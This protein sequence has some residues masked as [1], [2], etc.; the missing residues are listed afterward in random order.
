MV[1]LRSLQPMSKDEVHECL[2]ALG[3]TDHLYGLVAPARELKK[4]MNQRPEKPT[5]WKLLLTVPPE[6]L[7]RTLRKMRLPRVGYQEKSMEL[8]LEYKRMFGH[9]ADSACCPS[10]H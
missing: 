3:L 6:R 4:A 10:T 8:G 2:A 9:I 5:L 1:A 7:S